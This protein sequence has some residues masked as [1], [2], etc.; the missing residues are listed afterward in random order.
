MSDRLDAVAEES[1]LTL[2]DAG[3][4]AS[5][6]ETRALRLT[7]SKQDSRAVLEFVAAASEENI[8]DRLA[9]LDSESVERPVERDLSLRVLQHHAASVNHQQYHEVDIV[10]VHVD[11]PDPRG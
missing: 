3:G 6:S 5:A 11:A 4:P 9:V 7:L 8:E 10:T 2:T 1:L